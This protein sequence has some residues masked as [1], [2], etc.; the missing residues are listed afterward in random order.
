MSAGIPSAAGLP[1]E[2]GP[3]MAL[4]ALLDAPSGVAVGP[5]L[6]WLSAV[7]GPGLRVRVGLADPGPL[8][9]LARAAEREGHGTEVIALPT[10]GEAPSPGV[11]SVRR[12]HPEVVRLGE[13]LPGEGD[14]RL[15]SL[16]SADMGPTPA[17][18][19]GG[20]VVVDG[21]AEAIPGML[22]VA[23]LGP[24]TVGLAEAGGILAEALTDP[25]VAAPLG[26]VLARLARPDA[27][28]KAPDAWALN[29]ARA[30]AEARLAQVSQAQ[31]HALTAI[32]EADAL[33]AEATRAAARHDAELA[34]IASA[35]AE[36]ERLLLEARVRIADLERDAAG[37]E[38]ALA[39]RFEE[40]AILTQE[41]MRR[42]ARR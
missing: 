15:L 26:A 6:M 2:P 10:D 32:R 5:A 25:A 12:D 27:V 18:A 38:R 7:V 20:L 33:R 8:A 35:T 29:E 40:I 1:L 24:V 22:V 3:L 28:L 23:P 4:A 16:A 19:P 13:G 9:A 30:L 34:A 36:R 21:A 17:P 37:R 41:A 31:G 39:E 42:E 11:L 14:V